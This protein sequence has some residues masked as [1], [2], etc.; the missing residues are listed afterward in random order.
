MAHEVDRCLFPAFG[1][2]HRRKREEAV[3]LANHG[4]RL[5]S[6]EGGPGLVYLE[7][8]ACGLPVI[9]CSGSGAAEV[10]T[11]GVNGLLVPPHDRDALAGALRSLLGCAQTR[12]A[13]NQHG[14]GN[15]W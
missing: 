3:P 14:D 8:M 2:H 9:G 12:Q 13:C 1:R 6:Y 5:A 15:A 11:P 7:A 10:I 4:Y